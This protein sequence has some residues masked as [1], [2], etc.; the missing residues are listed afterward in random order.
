MYILP[1]AFFFDGSLLLSCL[2]V[3]WP[4][5][6]AACESFGPSLVSKPPVPFTSFVRS[7]SV[8]ISFILTASDGFMPGLGSTKACLCISI[9]ASSQ[10]ALEVDP[11]IKNH[12]K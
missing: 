5:D 9:A 12:H 1:G 6:D 3:A 10:S 8:L 7:L 11:E 2:H 4:V